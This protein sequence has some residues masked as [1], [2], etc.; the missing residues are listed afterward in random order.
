M[1]EIG[2]VLDALPGLQV[3]PHPANQITHPPAAEVLLPDVDYDRAFQRGLAALPMAIIVSVPQTL[4]KVTRDRLVRYVDPSEEQYSIAY[5]LAARTEANAWTSCAY[6]VAKQAFGVDHAVGNV[7][8]MS[9]RIPLQ[10]HG[11][12]T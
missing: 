6:V 3:F 8:Y 12:G 7:A 11:G 5:A 2:D 4:D 9:Y 1:D 10:I